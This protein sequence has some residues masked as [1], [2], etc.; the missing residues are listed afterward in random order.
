MPNVSA[1]YLAQ[2]TS[3]AAVR[4]EKARLFEEAAMSIK[5]TSDPQIAF[6]QDGRTATML[7]RKSYSRGTAARPESGE[8]LQEIGWQK[9]NRGWKIISERDLR[10]LR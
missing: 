2:N 10:V 7:F 4:A 8:V 5:R 6:A 1:F 3:R 9:T